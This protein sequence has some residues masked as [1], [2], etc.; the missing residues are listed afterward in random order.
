V[1]P[2]LSRRRAVFVLGKID[3]NL[4]WGKTKG[5]AKDARFVELGE[6]LSEVRSKQYWTLAKLKSF[7]EFPEK[8][9]P[10]SQQRPIT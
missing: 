7:S 9:F 5:Q 4:G 1:E 10:E 6:Y 8:H 3:E 2:E